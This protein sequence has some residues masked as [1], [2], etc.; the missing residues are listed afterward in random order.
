VWQDLDLLP[1]RAET[2]TGQT[3]PGSIIA[4]G[5]CQ[6]LRPHGDKSTT[7]R[8]DCYVKGEKGD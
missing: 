3:T 7:T 8:C 4:G 1:E 5:V 6:G 2:L